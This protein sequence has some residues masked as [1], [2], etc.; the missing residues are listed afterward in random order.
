MALPDL[1]TTADVSKETGVP[2][3][4][5]RWWRHSGGEVGPRSFVLGAKRVRYRRD[6]V[7]AWVERSYR[8]AASA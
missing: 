7:E 3:A 2:E 6:D 1:M 5:L 4:T 8:Q